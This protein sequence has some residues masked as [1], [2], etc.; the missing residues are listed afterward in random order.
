MV[1]DE[2]AD[3]VQTCGNALAT[4][5][6]GD[7]AIIMPQIAHLRP[8]PKVNPFANVRMAEKAFVILVDVTLK[9]G[10]FDLA[11]DAAVRAYSRATN[12]AAEDLGV[13]SDVARAFEA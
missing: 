5:R 13:G 10:C 2:R 3:L 8:G 12:L 6:H 1:A 11:T 4:H 7:F 9:D